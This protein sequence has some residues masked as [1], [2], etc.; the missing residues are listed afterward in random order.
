[1][2]KIAQIGTFNV[3]NLGDLLFPV[4]FEKL[5]GEVSG[6]LNED[7]QIIIFSPNS[8]DYNPTYKD[9]ITVKDLREFDNY[10]FDHT[11]IGGG[12][13]LRSDDW[14]INRLYNST[15]LSFSGIIS[16]SNKPIDNCYTLGLGVPFK[17]E[18]GFSEYI[19]NSF[20]RYRRISVRD[21]MSKELLAYHGVN[22][23]IVPDIVV[24]IS[25]YYPKHSLLENLKSISTRNNCSIEPGE[26]IVFQ[27]NDTVLQ[28]DEIIQVGELL[29]NISILLKIPVI[30]L[31]IG[32]CLGDNELFEKLGPLLGNCIVF[33]KSADPSLTLIDKVSIVANSKGFIGSSLHGNIISY[34][35]NVPFVTFT[36][37][38]ST[39]ITGFFKLTNNEQN[40]FKNPNEIVSK[41]A[42][43]FAELFSSN[44]NNDESVKKY[45]EVIIEFIKGALIDQSINDKIINYSA[46]LDRLFKIEQTII[47]QKN[48]E[49]SEL[50]ERVNSSEEKSSLLES[51][52]SQLWERVS[53][54]ERKLSEVLD[55]NDSLWKRVNDSETHLEEQRKQIR[56]L[57]DR[58]NMTELT[59]QDINEDYLIMK[60]EIEKLTSRME[61]LFI[62]NEQLKKVK[63][64]YEK[65]IFYRI[66]KKI[67]GR[68]N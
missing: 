38:Y 47:T 17:F 60:A 7:Y 28:E 3:D 37:E 62:E 43:F 66:K 2:K 14:S 11:F 15:Q 68:G 52:N 57:W 67:M 24:S 42:S 5:I 27:G 64:E 25:R 23:E 8:Y 9:Q 16:P 41:K 4:V 31:S 36:G 46:D 10:S 56:E 1:M 53:V 18:E 48:I 20:Y 40:C 22:S 29:N 30:L 59:N 55:Q 61:N 50:W 32:E 33:N 51:V 49:V 26:Y 58:V 6:L 13:L 21:N 19:K 63:E 34:S 44:V 54:S 45:T 39:K 65:T 35:Y 12:D